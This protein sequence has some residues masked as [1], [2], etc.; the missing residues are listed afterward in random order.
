MTDSLV[1]LA[2]FRGGLQVVDIANPSKPEP[3]GSFIPSL[4]DGQ[5]TVQSNDVF[6]DDRGLIYLLDRVRGLDIL[7]YTG[8]RP[9][10]AG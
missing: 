9:S 4:F 8:P 10:T 2:W 5:K 1:Y 3:V 6:V 7:E